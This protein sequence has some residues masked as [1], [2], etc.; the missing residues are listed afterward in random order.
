[1][2]NLKPF[3]GKNVIETL[4][5]GMYDDPRFIYREYIQNAADQIDEAVELGILRRRNQGRIHIKIDADNRSIR[6]EDNATG[7]KESQV[8]DFLGDVANSQKDR[9]IRKGFRGI[10]RLG[11]LGYCNQLVFET[12]YQGEA[13]KTVMTMDAVALRR[14]IDNKRDHS[15]ASAVISVITEIKKYREDRDMHYFNVVL[16]DVFNEP[17]MDEVNVRNYLSMVAPVAFSDEFSFREEI[18][19]FLKESKIQ[20]DEYSV[21][22]NEV[23]VFKS[24]K[25]VLTNELSIARRELTEE[26]KK[27]FAAYQETKIIFVDFF[28]VEGEDESTIGVGWIGVPEDVNYMMDQTFNERGIRL[29]KGNIQIGSEHTLTRFFDT[30]RTNLRLVGEL[31]VFDVA[32][33]PNARRDYF[34]ENHTRDVLEGALTKMFKVENWENKYAQKASNIYNRLREIKEFNELVKEFKGLTK[35][36]VIDSEEKEAHYIERVDNAQR[37]AIRAVAVLDKI[38]LTGKSDPKIKRL[39]DYLISGK[40]LALVDPSELL[41]KNVYD[42]PKFS[43]L[44]AEQTKIAR[45]IIQLLYEHLPLDDAEL[46]KRKIIEKYN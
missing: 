25:D 33:I 45:G 26:E 37:K 34:N 9:T 46:M 14:I 7:V 19:L 28:K 24:Y 17:L 8:R 29:K 5:S 6:I 10:G 38:K 43:K 35:S 13:V 41:K 32:L 39:Y 42:P 4:T 30:E 20:L 40:S 11:G 12:S 2:S 15:D 3:I 22:L 18:Y 21:H 36:G 44:N 31:H 23:P 1:M 27:N 16:K